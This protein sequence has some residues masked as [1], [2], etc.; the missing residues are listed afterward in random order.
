M[1]LCGR[2]RLRALVVPLRVLPLVL[3]P[4]APGGL[5]RARA[6]A[7]RAAVALPLSSQLP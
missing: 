5:A 3:A 4:L 6:P 1:L 7:V 2:L